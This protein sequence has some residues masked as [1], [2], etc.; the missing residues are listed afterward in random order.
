MP[1][2]KHQLI[3]H[4][5]SAL[6]RSGSLG[7]RILSEMV[8]AALSFSRAEDALVPRFKIGE[9]VFCEPDYEQL[10]LWADA[11]RMDPDKVLSH[12]LTGNPDEGWEDKKTLIKHGRMVRI[13][14]NIN[15]LPLDKFEWV[16]GLV[17]ESIT[18]YLNNDW[19]IGREHKKFVLS[20][21]LKKLHSF[22]CTLYL[23]E[24]L[25]ISN[26]PNLTRLT[27]A[28]DGP[29]GGISKI[30]LSSVTQLTE[31][32]CSGCQLKELDLSPVRKLRQIRCSHNKISRLDFS[33]T[34]LIESI[35][36]CANPLND[37]DLSKIPHLRILSCNSNNLTKI[38]LSCVPEL[39]SL[40][41]SR[42]A[43]TELDILVV[44][45][46]GELWCAHNKITKLD[47]SQSIDITEIH[48][49]DNQIDELDLSKSTNLMELHCANNKLT[50][51]DLSAAE[52]I[53]NLDCSNNQ[54][55]ELDVRSLKNLK[56]IKYDKDKTRLIQRPDQNF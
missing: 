15:L 46:L 10:I 11:L 36:C 9:H 44:P 3:P 22:F 43:L 4:T 27:C 50:R 23:L 52:R 41:C 48:C 30:D 34:P 26:T 31:L 38:D 8:D 7:G 1:E 56:K 12:L 16:N 53:T 19:V 35:V 20:L 33:S 6:A 24:E 45:R 39:K 5:G 47:L 28:N 32:D 42:N 14:W 55:V 40:A 54:I 21:P 18:F 17:I 25:D 13:G 51:L 37:I 49:S 29:R 2:D